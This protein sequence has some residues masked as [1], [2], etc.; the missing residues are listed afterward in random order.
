M[1]EIQ[2]IMKDKLTAKDIRKAVKE[3]EKHEVKPDGDGLITVDIENPRE[4]TD[5]FARKKREKELDCIQGGK[6][7]LLEL[8]L[9][10][11][12]DYCKKNENRWFTEYIDANWK[13]EPIDFG[14]S[15]NFETIVNKEFIITPPL[16]G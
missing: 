7:S 5:F 4:L 10:K 1:K 3:L 12:E 9:T 14:K 16:V 8:K 13:F 6:M 2:I 15:L 11:L